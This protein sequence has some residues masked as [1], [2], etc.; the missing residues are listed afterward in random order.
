MEFSSLEI[1]H[2]LAKWPA[3]GLFSCSSNSMAPPHF[4]RKGLGADATRS[5]CGIISPEVS[6]EREIVFF[7]CRCDNCSRYPART[8]EV[9][10]AGRS[11]RKSDYR[12]RKRAL[13]VC[14]QCCNRCG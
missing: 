4:M 2:N 1:T 10:S 7:V 3:Y 13:L 5:R 12:K 11:T 9:G 14:E 8:G 6:C